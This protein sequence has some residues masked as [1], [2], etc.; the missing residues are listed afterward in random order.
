MGSHTREFLAIKVAQSLTGDDV[1]RLLTDIARKRNKYPLGTQAGNGSDFCQPN[2]NP[3]IE[4]FNSHSRGECLNTN[5]F[6]SLEDARRT[7]KTW[8]QGYNHSRPHLSLYDIPPV[9][10]ARQFY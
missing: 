8:R 9:L 2:D 3:L 1:V 7:I 6:V 10:F 5:Y 4:S